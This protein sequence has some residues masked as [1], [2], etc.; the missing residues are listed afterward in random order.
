M[1]LYKQLV[2]QY[3]NF[4][5]VK[6]GLG[7]QLRLFNG[8]LDE[9]TY[10]ARMNNTWIPIQNIIFTPS[11]SDLTRLQYI[12]QPS[13]DQIIEAL[14]ID[15]SLIRYVEQPTCEMLIT[16]C[17]AR[18]SCINS[19]DHILNTTHIDCAVQCQMAAVTNDPMSL[20]YISSPYPEVCIQA[21]TLDHRSYEYVPW[22]HKQQLYDVYIKSRDQ[23][24]VEW[25]AWMQ[26]MTTPVNNSEKEISRL[27][28]IQQKNAL[29][30]WCIAHDI[31][32][33]R[34]DMSRCK[35]LYDHI[36]TSCHDGVVVESPDPAV[37]YIHGIIIKSFVA[38]CKQQGKN[39]FT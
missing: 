2:K 34:S 39:I 26:N 27:E 9:E 3:P 20:R 37:L 22:F 28:R 36:I 13:K 33:E 18:G 35:Q 30:L 32:I 7:K 6:H 25:K 14:A 31:D 8:K 19:I 29:D 24:F 1:D 10:Y 21:I 12:W 5:P 15:P 11:Q 16:A 23:Q 17:K 38:E 4:I